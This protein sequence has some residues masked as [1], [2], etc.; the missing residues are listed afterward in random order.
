MLTVN[1]AF[2]I[3]YKHLCKLAYN[4][5]FADMRKPYI[6]DFAIAIQSFLTKVAADQHRLEVLGIAA[7]SQVQSADLNDRAG[8]LV[9]RSVKGI[10]PAGK[11]FQ[12]NVE[13]WGPKPQVVSVVSQVDPQHTVRSQWAMTC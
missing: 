9:T 7:A 4:V 8:I 2:D 5:T 10:A 1:G 11:L 13:L 3:V 6:G 12:A